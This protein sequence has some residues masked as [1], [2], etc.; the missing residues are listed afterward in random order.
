M[1]LLLLFDVSRLTAQPNDR[2]AEIE[3]IEAQI[4]NK[5]ERANW[6][7]ESGEMTRRTREQID[8]LDAEI[9]ALR[10]RLGDIRKTVMVAEARG[11]A[12]REFA[13][14]VDQMWQAHPDDENRKA[15]R[16]RI[17]QELRRIIEWIR[18]EGEDLI[19]W[20]QPT[21]QWQLGF[22]LAA[23]R[24]HSQ[25]GRLPCVEHKVSS[26]LF[27]SSGDRQEHPV[28]LD[29]LAGQ[30]GSMERYIDGTALAEFEQATREQ[31]K[32]IVAELGYIPATA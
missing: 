5:D 20:L 15:L 23:S 2:A 10:K 9:A 25:R 8:K 16:A 28:T 32:R 18:A 24:S 27:Q 1:A 13:D 19:L 21:P 3:G 26:V 4:R 29:K 11:D 14:L 17:S 7:A 6:L 12:H 22:R 30:L 31:T